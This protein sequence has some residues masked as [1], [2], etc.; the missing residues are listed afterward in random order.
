MFILLFLTHSSAASICLFS[1]LNLLRTLYFFKPHN[2]IR[3]PSHW[4]IVLADLF[5]ICC[6]IA[7]CFKLSIGAVLVDAA[8]RSHKNDGSDLDFVCE[9]TCTGSLTLI[10][11]SPLRFLWLTN[12]HKLLHCCSGEARAI[13]NS[14]PPTPQHPNA[15]VV[16]T[17]SGICV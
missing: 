16:G 8:S 15:L 6:T 2:I 7:L 11:L 5:G 12:C 3:P 14:P 10:Y 4:S 13:S 9:D 1:F 17:L